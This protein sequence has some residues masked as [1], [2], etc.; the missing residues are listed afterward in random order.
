MG[1]KSQGAEMP[2]EKFREI[3]RLHELGRNQTEI[4]LAGAFEQKPTVMK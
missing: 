4:G 1:A 3:I 2:M